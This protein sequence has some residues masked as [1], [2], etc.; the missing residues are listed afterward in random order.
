M[1]VN[2]LERELKVIYSREKNNKLQMFCLIP[3]TKMP[4]KLFWLNYSEEI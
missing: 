3:H 1:N 4:L 2:E